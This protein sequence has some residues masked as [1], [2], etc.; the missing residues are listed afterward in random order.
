MAKKEK[1]EETGAKSDAFLGKVQELVRLFEALGH[2]YNLAALL[3]MSEAAVDD[4]IVAYEVELE[5]KIAEADAAGA[6]TPSAAAPQASSGDYEEVAGPLIV[7]SMDPTSR[8]EEIGIVTNKVINGER[9]R[10]PGFGIMFKEGR[11]GVWHSDMDYQVPPEVEDFYLAEAR[12]AGR[13]PGGPKPGKT[14][15]L[16][17][18]RDKIAR[19]VARMPG[20]YLF[21][22]REEFVLVQQESGLALKAAQRATQFSLNQKDPL[23]AKYKEVLDELDAKYPLPIA[24]ATAVGGPITAG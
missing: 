10:V 18:I 11:R 12:R 1:S 14:V 17:M 5:A 23:F 15:I 6:P 4:A 19:K 24:T 16:G 3:N 8:T 21:I 9:Y 22:D 7:R 20:S 13:N 2:E